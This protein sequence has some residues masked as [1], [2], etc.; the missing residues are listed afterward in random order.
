MFLEHGSPTLKLK[1]GGG[2]KV[3]HGDLRTYLSLYSYS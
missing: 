3:E 2:Y 1:K